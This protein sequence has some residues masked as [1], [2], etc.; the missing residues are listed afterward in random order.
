MKKTMLSVVMLIMTFVH[1]HANVVDSAMSAVSSTLNSLAST[2]SSS[3][4]NITSLAQNNPHLVTAIA[5]FFSRPV[6]GLLTQAEQYSLAR[7][8]GLRVTSDPS[9]S[10]ATLNIGGLALQATTLTDDQVQQN[11]L[12]SVS[13]ALKEVADPASSGSA[14]AVA[15]VVASKKMMKRDVSPVVVQDLVDL[16]QGNTVWAVNV[17]ANIGQ[18]GL[19]SSVSL[20]DVALSVLGA[21]AVLALQVTGSHGAIATSSTSA[22]EA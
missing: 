12:A 14:H 1:V 13:A 3:A 15:S 5:L 4:K 7:L 16:A 17:H 10:Q 9:S 21:L 8:A 6:L 22:V 11:G 19:Q 20:S 2:V 18:Y